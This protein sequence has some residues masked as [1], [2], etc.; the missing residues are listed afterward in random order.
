MSEATSGFWLRFKASLSRR[1]VGR[2]LL[3]LRREHIFGRFEI[4]A[5]LLNPNND[6]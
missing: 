1:L 5:R 6:P 4:E 2:N 3:D